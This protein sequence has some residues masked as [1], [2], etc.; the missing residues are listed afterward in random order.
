MKEIHKQIQELRERDLQISKTIDNKETT[1][2]LYKKSEK[3]S[4]I[5]N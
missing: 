4:S 5:T 3:H 1:K 2:E